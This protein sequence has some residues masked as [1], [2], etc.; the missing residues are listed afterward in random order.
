MSLV[1]VCSPQTQAELDTVVALLEARDVPCFVR[2]GACGS[3]F[4]PVQLPRRGSCTVMVPAHCQTRAVE[5]IGQLHG[6]DVAPEGDAPDRN[7]R[8]LRALLGLIL[9]V[10]LVPGRGK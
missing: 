5:L 8:S 4:Y 10:C 3:P 1:S 2:D 9:G 6:L 7:P